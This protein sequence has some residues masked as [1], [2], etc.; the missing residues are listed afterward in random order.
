M[1]NEIS[2]SVIEFLTKIVEV[3]ANA[4]MRLELRSRK[5]YHACAVFSLSRELISI[6]RNPIGNWARL[7][8]KGVSVLR[9]FGVDTADYEKRNF[10]TGRSR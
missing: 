1:K 7:T 2:S 3:D 6:A 8:E 10:S 4:G 5:K 9:D